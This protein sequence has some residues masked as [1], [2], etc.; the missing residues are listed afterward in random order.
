MMVRRIVSRI[1]W[2]IR[3]NGPP[4]ANG[5]PDRIVAR[6]SLVQLDGSASIDPEGAPL[7]YHW[8][9]NAKPL[10][11]S[12]TLSNPNIVNPCVHG[13]SSGRVLAAARGQRRSPNSAADIVQITT[14]NQAPIAKRRDRSQRCRHRRGDYA[15]R[16]PIG[17]PGWRSTL[18]YSW[19]FFFKPALSAA[20]LVGANTASPAFAAD[21]PGL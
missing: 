1:S 11:S 4:L 10:G 21:R 9:L 6:A 15:E 3:T 12:A 2:E 20:V 16:Q 18:V 19:E 5:G 8:T 17:R 14:A 7:A 13:R